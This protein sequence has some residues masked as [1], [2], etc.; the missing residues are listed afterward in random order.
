MFLSNCA[1]PS[2]LWGSIKS[3][4][5]LPLWEGGIGLR[6]ARRTAGS[7][8]VKLV[9]ALKMVK[10]RHPAVADTILRVLESGAESSSIQA[11]LKCTRIL[12]DAGFESLAWA[13]LV[14]GRALEF[15][16]EEENPASHGDRE[17]PL[18]RFRMATAVGTLKGRWRSQRGPLAST[19]LCQL[20][21][22]PHVKV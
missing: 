15:V 16:E 21:R 7:P 4:R 13:E 17:A 18:R 22:R 11:I 10:E 20:P 3:R 12:Q 14:A 1:D 6:S 9:D 5:V 2:K 8:L 19:P